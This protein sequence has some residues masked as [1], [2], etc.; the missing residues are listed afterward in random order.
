MLLGDV[1]D[2]DIYKQHDAAMMAVRACLFITSHDKVTIR[3]S[4]QLAEY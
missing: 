1:G 4:Q 3:R 2:T